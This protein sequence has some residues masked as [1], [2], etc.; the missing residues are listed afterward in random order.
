MLIRMSCIDP[1]TLNGNLL[2]HTYPDLEEE[3][4]LLVFFFSSVPNHSLH[5]YLKTEHKE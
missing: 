5:Q 1:T 4:I 2:I 3:Q